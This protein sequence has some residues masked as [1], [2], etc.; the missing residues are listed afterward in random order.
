MSFLIFKR[1]DSEIEEYGVW[2]K[3][4]DFL[5]DIAFHKK[6]KKFAYYPDQMIFEREIYL[7]SMCLKEIY[8][9]LEKVNKD[10]KEDKEGKE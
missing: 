7:C 1:K 3:K 4:K 5:G 10:A 2:N 6:W 9:F 8:E